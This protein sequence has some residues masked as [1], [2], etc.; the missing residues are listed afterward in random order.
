[1]IPT[2]IFKDVYGE[3]ININDVKEKSLETILAVTNTDVEEIMNKILNLLD[4]K[5]KY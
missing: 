2:E 3:T 4:G 5:I 1:M